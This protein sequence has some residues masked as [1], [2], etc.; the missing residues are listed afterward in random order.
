MFRLEKLPLGDGTGGT[1]RELLALAVGGGNPEHEPE[2][3][4]ELEGQLEGQHELEDWPES[5]SDPDPD[6]AGGPIVRGM[7]KTAKDKLKIA[8]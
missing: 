6:L 7:D 2:G 4:P 8:S 5:E 3:E 1:L